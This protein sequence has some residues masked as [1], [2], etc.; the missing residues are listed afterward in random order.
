MSINKAILLGNVGADP[1]VRDINGTKVA[2]L[3]LATSEK[4]YTKRDGTQVP[5]R[6]EWHRIVIWG[7]LA[8]VVERYVSKGSKLYIEGRITNRS[9]TD[10]DNVTRY[11]SEVVCEKMEML[12]SKPQAQQQPYQ[13]PYQDPRAVAQQVY[14]QPQQQAYQQPQPQQ[15]QGYDGLPPF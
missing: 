8:D 2:Q 15:P 4:A 13:Q 5:E 10:K 12:G 14:Q 9:Y 6:T 1:Q 7:A 11:I 3:S